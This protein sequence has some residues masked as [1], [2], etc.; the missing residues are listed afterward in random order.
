MYG[1]NNNY[2]NGVISNLK[3]ME[4]H[5]HMMFLQMLTS[6]IWTMASVTTT[7]PT[8][9]G[10]TLVLAMKDMYWLRTN[11]HAMVMDCC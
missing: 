7:V 6:V 5:A 2:P 1:N 11:K 9:P 10:V 3:V 4:Y 8:F